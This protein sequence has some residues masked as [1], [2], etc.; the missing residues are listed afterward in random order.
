MGSLNIGAHL[1]IS[2]GLKGLLREAEETG[3][4]CFQ[5]FMRNPRGGKAKDYPESD[6]EH[7][8]KT[9]E[10]RKLGP[11]L[12]HAPYTMNPAAKK[13][14]LREY[15]LETMAD[16]IKRAT[17]LGNAMYNF[18]PGSHVGQGIEKGIEL[19]SDLLNRLLTEDTSIPVLLET[20]A[21]KG[22]EVGSHF[23]ELREIIDRTELGDKLGVCLDTCH[24]FD[25]G[26]DIKDDLDGVLAEFDR[27]VGL[28]RLRAIHLN[29]SVFGLSSHKDRHAKISEG[30]LGAEAIS[31]IINHPLLRR[32]PFYLETPN[33]LR[34]Y[35]KEI[36]LLRSLC[37]EEQ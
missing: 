15:A 28:S 35:S 2:G 33:D 16:D 17:A 14:E 25:G 12:V 36:S 24:I 27:T 10:E 18:H 30:G 32:L 3:S 7:F 34:G 1:S 4:S 11:F 22:S 19:I 31:R 37:A 5:F 20:M 23:E 21:G 6:I 9:A 26:Y 13:P 8:R 29:D